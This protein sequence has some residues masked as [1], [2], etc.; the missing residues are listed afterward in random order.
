MKV[1]IKLGGSLLDDRALCASI[2]AQISALPVGMQAVVVHGGGKQMT[3]FLNERGV[4][5]R[6]VDGLRVTTPEVADAVLKVFAGSVNKQLA[7]ALLAAGA[8]A[9]G[10]SGIDGGLAVARQLNPALGAVG[11]VERVNSRLLDVLLEGGYLPVVACVAGGERGEV[12]NVN[13]DQM[14]VACAGAWQAEKLWFLTDIAGVKGAD[15]AVIGRL[16]PSQ[17]R[18]LIETGVATLGM[19]AKLESACDA[20]AHGIGEVRIA[21]GAE[22]AILAQLVAARTAAAPG[23]ALIPEQPA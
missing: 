4:E 9:V 1:L 23:T 21:P 15:G 5:S 3:R 13:A 14:A 6:F 16:T 7:G 8:P 20:L 17:A 22:P 11:R 2:A 12:F 19:Q 10:L 18:R